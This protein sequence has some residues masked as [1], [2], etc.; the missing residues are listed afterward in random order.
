[1]E[2]NLTVGSQK[3]LG[4]FDAGTFVEMGAYIKR[5]SSDDVYDGIICGYGAVSGKLTFAFV[6]D[7]DRQKGAFDATGAKKIQMLYDAAIKNGAPVIGVFDTAGA[8][9]LDGSATLSAYGSFMSCVAKASGIIPQ[10]AIIDGQCTGMALVTAS[11]FDLVISV[12]G[13]AVTYITPDSKKEKAIKVA[14]KAENEDVAF[15]SARELIEILPQNNNDN[16][17]IMSG[18]DASRAVSV[19]GLTGA[20]LVGAIADNGK[21]VELYAGAAECVSTGLAFFG[22]QL[23]GV[24]ASNTNSKKGG[25][26]C[27]CGA[28]KAAE[29]ISLCDRFGISLLTLVDSAGFADCDHS[30][31][32][33]ALAY[34]Y[35]NS[36][37]AKVSVVTGKA[38]GASFTL[39]GSKSVG[40]DIEF[41]LEGSVI[42][43]MSPESAVAFL[44]NDKISA[45]KSRADVEAEWCKKYASPICAAEKGDIDD[46][47][48]PEELRARICSALYMLALKADKAPDRKYPRTPLA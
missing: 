13:K 7:S 44:M 11:M 27:G 39:L 33:A 12:D 17:C 24:V 2:K 38:Y 45:D 35:I 30:E 48:P 26:L 23:C 3:I 20:A 14:I 4:L 10:I 34:A 47:I 43:V 31:A 1:M 22:G 32:F 29:M 25:K 21:F 36:T 40:A 46:I 41:A 18:D 37:C 8:V 28:K 42:S 19:D 5:C 9:V 16:A 6:Q 15:S